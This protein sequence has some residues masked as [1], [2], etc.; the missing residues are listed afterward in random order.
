MGHDL[1]C[2]CSK[3]PIQLILPVKEGLKFQTGYLIPLDKNKEWKWGGP[4]LPSFWMQAR[5]GQRTEAAQTHGWGHC[6]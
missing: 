2:N 1:L 5:E 3:K 6:S 4:F